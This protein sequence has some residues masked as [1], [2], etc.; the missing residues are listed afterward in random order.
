MIRDFFNLWGNF[1]LFTFLRDVHK[2]CK[3]QKHQHPCS[4][5][6]YLPRKIVNS[7]RLYLILSISNLKI[8]KYTKSNK[9]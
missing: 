1:G 9:I 2:D 3:V 5:D 4:K 7:Y 8:H 6:S